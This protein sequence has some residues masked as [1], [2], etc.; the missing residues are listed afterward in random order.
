MTKKNFRT[1]VTP[2][3]IDTNKRVQTKET[4][5]INFL[6]S[7]IMHYFAGG[8]AIGAIALFAL[9]P[10]DTQAQVSA[11]AHSAITMTQSV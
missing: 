10:S 6:K 8:F 9:Q 5:M 2:S 4:T 11:Q 7:E 3:C 1:H